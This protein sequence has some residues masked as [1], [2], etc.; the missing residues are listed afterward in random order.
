MRYPAAHGFYPFQKDELTRTIDKMLSGN[1]EKIKNPLGAIVPH[2]GYVFSGSTAAKTL[3]AAKSDKK[4][5]F[6]LGLSH[7]GHETS[8]S[9]QDWETPLGDVKVNKKIIEKLDIEINERAHSS[10]HSLEV[11]IPFLQTMYKDFDIVP[12]ALGHEKFENL[13]KMADSFPEDVFYIASTDFIHYGPM[14]GYTPK[15]GSVQDQLKWAKKRN[16]ELID[17]ICSLKAREFYD[18]VIKNNYT[19]CGFIP[20]TLMILTMKKLGAKGAKLIEYK[21]SYEVSRSSS[22]VCYAGLVFYW[23]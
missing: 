10:E 11:I 1:V 22:F 15:K 13:E 16:L 7:R 20:V 2:A 14:Y 9:S 8:L 4:T 18:S 21:T 12:L 23:A 5:F 17:M 3:K 19:V 6:V